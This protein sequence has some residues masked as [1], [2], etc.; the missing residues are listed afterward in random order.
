[1]RKKIFRK[2]CL[3][4]ALTSLCS[5]GMSAC[6]S[7]KDKEEDPPAQE[8]QTE[9]TVQYTDEAG[10]HQINVTSGMPYA[11]EA[12]PFRYGYEFLG[13]YD[14]EVGGTQYVNASGASV[15]PFTDNKNLVLFPQWKAK[16]FTVVLDYQG[17]EVVGSR[18]LTVAYNA[19]IPELPTNLAVEHKNFKGWYTEPNCEGEQIADKYGLDPTKKI[20]TEKIYDLSDENGFVY[21]YAGFEWE[22]F[23]VTFN[24]D[25][26]MPAEEMDVAYNTPISQAV[27]TTRNSDGEAV[28]IWSRRQNDTAMTDVFTGKVTGEM[29][30]YAVEW[31]PVI[32]FDVNG[33]DDVV[34]LVARAGETIA[35]PTPTKDLAKFVRWETLSG[36]TYSATTMPSTSKKLKA[37]WQGK[38]VFDENGGSRVDDISVPAGT[39]VTLPTPEKEGYIFAGWY[40]K[41]RELYTSK[42]MPANG[43]ALQAAWY[44][45]KTEKITIKAATEDD[46]WGRNEIGKTNGPKADWRKELDISEYVNKEGTFVYISF[47]IKMKN[48]QSA[49][50]SQA[51][52]Y[53]YNDPVVS[54]SNL[55]AKFIDTVSSD[56]FKN[57]TFN[58]KIKV[59]KELK[60]YFCYY[61]YIQ[62]GGKGYYLKEVHYNDIW[63]ELTYPDTTYLYY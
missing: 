21:L 41:D 34:P 3:A 25:V 63:L 7:K 13:L 30:L 22:T 57:Y 60:L 10:T 39:S 55:Q 32:D 9:F 58:A 37:V 62:S 43:V 12:V 6:F 11:L 59:G 16:D 36:S 17:A 49:T 48:D 54:D 4:M 24:F 1:M 61:L 45:A 46:A 35:L 42:T 29:V 27:P 5:W 47:N 15:S 23:K 8:Q 19:S 52:V 40:T 20:L 31:A 50:I 33:G 14:A 18:S 53:V 56:A 38:L 26:G 44:K 2:F 28:L 51:G